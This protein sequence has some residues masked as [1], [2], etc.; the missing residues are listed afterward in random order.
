VG[1]ERYVTFVDAK[2]MK[3]RMTDRHSKVPLKV[4]AGAI[5]NRTP[6]KESNAKTL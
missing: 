4:D 3:N 5:W 1:V 2:S 6:E